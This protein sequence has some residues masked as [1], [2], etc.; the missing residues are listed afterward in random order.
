MTSLLDADEP[1]F[2]VLPCDDHCERVVI[3][4]PYPAIT[5]LQTQIGRTPL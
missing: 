2:E 5:G 1:G 3:G 4:E